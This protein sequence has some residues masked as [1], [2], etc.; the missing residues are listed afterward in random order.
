[1]TDHSTSPRGS[2]R[3]AQESIAASE[4]DRRPVSVRLT[5]EARS[6]LKKMAHR[7]GISQSAVLELAI[8]NYE[9]Y[10][11]RDVEARARVR[12]NLGKVQVQS[13]RPAR[14]EL[15][16]V[17]L[18]K[19]A[20]R[21]LHDAGMPLPDLLGRYVSGDWGDLGREDKRRI[22]RQLKAGEN[23]EGVYLL[24]NKRLIVVDTDQDRTQT[25][26]ITYEDI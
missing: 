5:A 3:S 12:T 23:V 9:G 15:G 10:Y 20:K 25:S 4:P 6:T 2:L 26:V 1:M 11:G 8:R 18:S 24:P 13:S 14:F 16:E 21:A 19:R 17:H 22:N 7:I